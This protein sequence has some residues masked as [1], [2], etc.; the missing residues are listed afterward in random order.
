M[1]YSVSQAIYNITLHPLAKFPGP[2]WRGAFYFP[3]FHEIWTGDVV[4]NWHMLHEKYGKIVRISPTCLSFTGP[5]A[6]KDIYG[7]AANK[8]SFV[9]DPD[10]YAP[11]TDGVADI[12]CKSLDGAEDAE[13]DSM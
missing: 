13:S 10:V 6:W 9:K 3:F 11:P 7:Q 5:D 1:V 12:G 8:R 4:S 2:R